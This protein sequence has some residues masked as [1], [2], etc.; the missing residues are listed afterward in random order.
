MNEFHWLWRCFVKFCSAKSWERKEEIL[1]F[2]FFS[3]V[4]PDH[5]NVGSVWKWRTLPEME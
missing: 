5:N 2:F 4:S 3:S 1:D